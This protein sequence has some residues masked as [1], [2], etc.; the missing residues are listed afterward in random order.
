M[1]LDFGVSKEYSNTIQFLT[2]FSFSEV[3]EL[4]IFLICFTRDL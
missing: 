2:F 3:A 1:D 4:V